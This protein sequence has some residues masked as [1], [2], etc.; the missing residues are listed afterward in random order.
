LY[1]ILRVY[2]LL[3]GSYMFKLDE[4]NGLIF[5]AEDLKEVYEP[6]VAQFGF[7]YSAG[8]DLHKNGLAWSKCYEADPYSENLWP[9]IVIRETGNDVFP[10]TAVAKYFS[11]DLYWEDCFKSGFTLGINPDEFDDGSGDETVVF[12]EIV[13]EAKKE[14]NEILEKCRQQLAAK[15]LSIQDKLI[16]ESNKEIAT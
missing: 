4:S 7:E 5:R 15:L 16:A 1:Y 2:F 12:F 11:T 14:A 8:F 3:G 10:D 9:L 6:I 13:N